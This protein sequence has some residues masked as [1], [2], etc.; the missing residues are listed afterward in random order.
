MAKLKAVWLYLWSRPWFS[1]PAAA[2]LAVLGQ[3][4][5]SEASSGTFVWNAATIHKELVLAAS[6][7]IL[8]LH[9][10]YMQPK[11]GN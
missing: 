1:T 9:Q 11:K 2:A 4:I 6:A 10:L 8:S 5:Y 7:A 3:F